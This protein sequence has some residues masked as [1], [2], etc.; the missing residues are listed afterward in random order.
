MF[1]CCH[2]PCR[3]F[4]G[5]VSWDTESGS[6]S[7]YLESDD[8]ITHQV[9]DRPRQGHIFLSRCV[10][11]RLLSVHVHWCAHLQRM[12]L[13]AHHGDALVIV[14]NVRTYVCMYVCVYVCMYV[15]VYVRMTNLGSE[16]QE[17]LLI[18]RLQ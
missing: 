17:S 9:V 11:E 16:L 10:P 15:C 4:G 2:F 12:C 3:S 6:G 1:I 7:T 13:V 14:T 8:S 5:A 18:S